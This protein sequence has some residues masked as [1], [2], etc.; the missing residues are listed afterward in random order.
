MTVETVPNFNVLNNQNFESTVNGVDLVCI[1]EW[2]RDDLV[3]KSEVFYTV[4]PLISVSQVRLNIICRRSRKPFYSGGT[5]GL[6]G[7]IFCDLLDHN[8]I[9][10]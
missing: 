1:T 2:D 4:A 7:Y 5:Y 8:Y 6:L 10:P 9:S 3:S